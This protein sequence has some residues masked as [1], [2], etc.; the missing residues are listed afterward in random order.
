MLGGGFD[1]CGGDGFDLFGGFAVMEWGEAEG[2]V[3]GAELS[4]G[5]VTLVGECLFGEPGGFDIL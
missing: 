1:F 3:D 2:G 5:A 4:H